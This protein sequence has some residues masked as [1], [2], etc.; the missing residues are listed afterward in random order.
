MQVTGFFH[1]GEINRW[2][3]SPDRSD[4]SLASVVRL[5]PLG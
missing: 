3:L 2:H 1:V 5:L 4:V